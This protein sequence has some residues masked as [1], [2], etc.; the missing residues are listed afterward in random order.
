MKKQS[1]FVIGIVV[2]VISCLGEGALS[3]L[4]HEQWSNYVQTWQTPW[5]SVNKKKV[6]KSEQ[7]IPLCAEKL[8]RVRI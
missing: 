6:K 2:V 4:E 5:A 8:A 1:I 3:I 7:E